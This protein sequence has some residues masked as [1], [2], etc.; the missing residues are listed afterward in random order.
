MYL[1][2]KIIKSF[3]KIN[4][5]YTVYYSGNKISSVETDGKDVQIF[6]TTSGCCIN[7]KGS[8]INLRD[9]D[10]IEALLVR[11]NVISKEKK[12]PKKLKVSENVSEIFS[13]T[14]K[15]FAIEYYKGQVISVVVENPQIIIHRTSTG[16]CLEMGSKDIAVEN[17]ASLK[18]VLEKMNI[19][20]PSNSKVN[21]KKKESI[22][23]EIP[24]VEQLS[25]NI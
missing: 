21:R 19:I 7:I 6:S 2:N 13:G 4:K 15:L 1:P 17:L 3:T 12:Q 25:L 16:Y 10:S 11:F 20:K 8:Q 18:K 14:K 9:L 22:A 23:N 24:G 5:P